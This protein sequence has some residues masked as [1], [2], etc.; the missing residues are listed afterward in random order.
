MLPRNTRGTGCCAG[1]QHWSAKHIKSRC[2]HAEELLKRKRVVAEAMRV[3]EVH[4]Q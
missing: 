1:M 2:E 4:P 3:M